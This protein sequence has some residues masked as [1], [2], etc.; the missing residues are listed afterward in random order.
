MATN[1]PASADVS[2]PGS[3]LECP[4]FL[5]AAVP[6]F[7]CCVCRKSDVTRIVFYG[8]GLFDQRGP[9]NIFLTL[10]RRP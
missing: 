7:F 4:V 3:S 5:L 9:P 8:A 1:A 6:V 10:Q 2:H